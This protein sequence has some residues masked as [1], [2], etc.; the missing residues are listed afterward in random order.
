LTETNPAARGAF[1]TTTSDCRQ[2]YHPTPP[3]PNFSP[4]HSTNLLTVRLL[5]SGSGTWTSELLGLTS[6]VIGNEEGSVV[7][8]KGL[9]E[10]VFAVL[11]NELLVVGDQ[12]LGNGLSD[13]VDLGSVTTTGDTYSDIDIGELVKANNEERL[14]DLLNWQ[15]HQYFN[16]FGH[17]NMASFS[18]QISYRAKKKKKNP[19]PA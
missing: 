1:R 19:Y 3:P 9:L 13:G 10:Q 4:N 18:V 11:I 15:H 6:S 17:T 2:P 16:S 12:G 7:L 8:H 5:E 14:I